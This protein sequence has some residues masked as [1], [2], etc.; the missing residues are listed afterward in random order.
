M[1]SSFSKRWLHWY[2]IY[3][4][5][6][7]FFFDISLTFS[8]V[9]LFVKNLQQFGSHIFHTSQMRDAKN[10]IDRKKTPYMCVPKDTAGWQKKSGLVV[11]EYT[12]VS[13]T[14]LNDQHKC[15]FQSKLPQTV[16]DS[17]LVKL[18]SR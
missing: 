10:V 6:L 11:S 9:L 18:T 17:G 16:I 8:K 2:K 1:F 13:Q 14:A 5:F 15:L 4:I 3:I 12:E 7:E